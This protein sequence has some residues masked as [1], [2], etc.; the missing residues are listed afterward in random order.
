MQKKST[1]LENTGLNWAKGKQHKIN[2]E[3]NG[4]N[5]EFL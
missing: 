2:V 1:G 3:E 5:A 4:S